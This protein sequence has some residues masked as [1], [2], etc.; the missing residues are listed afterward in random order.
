MNIRPLNAGGIA[1][2]GCNEAMRICLVALAC[3]TLFGLIGCGANSDFKK[4]TGI[5]LPADS[6]LIFRE[7]MGTERA[8]VWLFPH[9]IKRFEIPNGLPFEKEYSDWS[10]PWFGYFGRLQEAQITPAMEFKIFGNS[11][12]HAVIGRDIKEKKIAM[13]VI[14]TD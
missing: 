5:D 6:R 3:V 14:R 11:E 10:K 7:E 4:I 12:V 13:S 8:Y 1:L 9:G 2:W